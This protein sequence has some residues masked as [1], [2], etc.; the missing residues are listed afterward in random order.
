MSQ[1]AGEAADSASQLVGRT[2]K[3]RVPA[4][5]AN[6]GPGYDSAGIALALYDDLEATILD[7][8]ELVIEVEGAGS[9]TLPRDGSHLVVRALARGLAESGIQTEGLHLKCTNRIPQGRGL[10]SSS[11][12]IVGGLALARELLR[13]VGQDL[14][15]QRLLE[16][17]NDLEGHPDNVA[18]A[19]FGGFT[20]AWQQSVTDPA[21]E[22]TGETMVDVY[23]HSVHPDIR[24]VLVIPNGDLSTERAR[25]LMPAKVPLADAAENAASASLL[26]VALISNPEL[27]LVGTSDRIHQYYRR[28][29]YPDSY[30]LMRSLRKVGIPAAISGAGP[31][32]I[33]FGVTG[34]EFDDEALCP[35]IVEHVEGLEVEQRTEFDVTPIAID[36]EGVKSL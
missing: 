6:L 29:A 24:P 4:T 3:V 20:I 18:P 10:G 35:V 19:I 1:L 22:P 7:T 36:V 33:V 31:S 2:V 21:G 27:L 32:V 5:S 13:Q 15:D 17:A 8:N 14:T 30:G 26:S 9:D 23:V 28:F 16:L 11:A 12:A 25:E 34:A